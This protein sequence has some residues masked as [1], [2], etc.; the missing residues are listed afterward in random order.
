MKNETIIITI[1][2]GDRQ[3]LRRREVLQAIADAIE[4][5][6]TNFADCPMKTKADALGIGDSTLMLKFGKHIAEICF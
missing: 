6:L 2:I 5:S 1:P 3:R 4:D